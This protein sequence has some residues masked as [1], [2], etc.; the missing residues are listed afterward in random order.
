MTEGLD[1]EQFSLTGND[2]G[3]AQP[4]RCVANALLAA[5]L[6]Q[7]GQRVEFACSQTM[8]RKSVADR[9]QHRVRVGVFPA[10]DSRHD[11]G[12]VHDHWVTGIAG[13]QPFIVP[14]APAT[15]RAPSKPA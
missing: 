2:E 10:T 4:C 1:L 3:Q 11:H 15:R 12:F 14:I 6:R 9:S 7:G 13:F 5:F 8:A